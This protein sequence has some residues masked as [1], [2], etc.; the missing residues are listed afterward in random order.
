MQASFLLI[1]VVIRPCCVVDSGY[2]AFPSLSCKL[3]IQD[4]RSPSF[5]PRPSFPKPFGFM[6]ES[7]M[8]TLSVPSVSI[9]PYRLPEVGYW[10]FPGVS[11]CKPVKKDLPTNFGRTLF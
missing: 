10:Q 3:V 8:A 1:S 2:N 11:V 5:T 7:V 6:V 4:C 9:S